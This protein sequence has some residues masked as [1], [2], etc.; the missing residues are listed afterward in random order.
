MSVRLFHGFDFNYITANSFGSS[1]N[2]SWPTNI[3]YLLTGYPYLFHNKGLA[4]LDQSIGPPCQSGS[5]SAGFAYI[6]RTVGGASV[7]RYFNVKSNS[8]TVKNPAYGAATTV[9]RS[10]FATAQGHQWAIK[11]NLVKPTLAND[12]DLYFSFELFT[13]VFP[14]SSISSAFSPSASWGWIFKWGDV[15]LKFKS[16]TYVSGTA[17][18]SFHDLVFSV[19]NGAS[20][21]ATVTVANVDCQ[22]TIN[23]TSPSLWVLFHAKLDASTGLIDCSIN[24]NAQSVS[25][26][27]QNTVATT[28]N[29]AADAIYFGPIIADDGTTAYTGG[30]DSLLIDDAAFPSGLPL[31]LLVTMASD[32]TLVDTSAVG[33]SATTV[34]NALTTLADAKHVRM[35]S[36]SATALL[37]LTMPTL[38][39]YLTDLLG[40]T[41][42]VTGLSNRYPATARKVGVGVDLSGSVVE[43]EYVKTKT[44]PFGSVITPPETSVTHM[45]FHVFEKSAGTKYTKTD[46]ASVKLKLLAK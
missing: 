2:S 34:T 8:G 24:G 30:F 25:Y 7:G 13:P 38:T 26:T 6:D 20:E 22:Q 27:G 41:G 37:N 3:L 28:S 33:T 14:A 19:M 31:C 21:V 5:S 40:F 23:A 1:G 46:A 29:A 36:I 32:G 9:T 15:G 17:T 12:T 35:T 16:S 45:P 11:R 10:T 42:Q 44:L 39:S 18:T 4:T 43:D